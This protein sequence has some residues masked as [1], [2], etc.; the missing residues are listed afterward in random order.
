MELYLT[1]RDGGGLSRAAI[2]EA[3][4]ASLE[5]RRVGRALLLPPDHTRIRSGAGEI[6]NY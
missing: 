4:E 6:A 5:G 2:R 1:D 3:L